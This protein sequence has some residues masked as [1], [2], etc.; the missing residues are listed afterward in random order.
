MTVIPV[1]VQLAPA[2]SEPPEKVI[3]SGVVVESEPPQVAVG[4]VVATVNPAG[5][6]SLNAIPLKAA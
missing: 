3:W 5:N 2:A 6:V 1:R 4:A